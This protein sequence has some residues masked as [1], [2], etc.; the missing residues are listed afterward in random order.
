[1]TE[2]LQGLLNRIQEDGLQKSEAERTRIIADAEAKAAQIIADAEAKAAETEKKAAQEAAALQTKAEESIRQ[3]A[4]D[5][6]IAL[7]SEMQQRLQSVTKACIGQAMNQ[8]LMVALIYEMAKKYAENPADKL[9][10]LLPASALEQLE[11][12]LLNAL[13]QDLASRTKILGEPEL[14][15]GLQIGFR[16]GSVFLD[17]SDEALSNLICSYI[18]PKLTAILKEG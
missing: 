5:I 9:E 12:G 1:M 6:I 4:R 18:G 8:N 7:R 15:S 17:F 11:S 13:G 16:D 2:D 3:A 14:E 10:V